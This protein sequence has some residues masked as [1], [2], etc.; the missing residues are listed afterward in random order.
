MLGRAQWVASRALNLITFGSYRETFCSR[1]YRKGWRRVTRPIDVL[2]YYTRG[3]KR[4]CEACWRWD[5]M[6]GRS[7]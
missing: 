2:F 4:H 6:N 7:V 1:A 3:Q 5:C